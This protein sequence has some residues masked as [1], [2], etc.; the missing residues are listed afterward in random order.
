MIAE[1]KSLLIANRGEIACR[2]IATAKKMGITTYVIYNEANKFSRYVSLSDYAIFIEQNSTDN[3][4][5][6]S[7][8][9]V[10]LAK[11]H[12][13]DAIHPG[14]GF[15]SENASFAAKVREA[16]LQFIG[17]TASCIKLMGNK[18]NAR[19]YLAQHGIPCIPGIMNVS[20]SKLSLE[21]AAELGYPIMIKASAGGG[22]RGMRRVDAE[23]ELIDAIESAM[24][25]AEKAFGDGIVYGEK[26]IAKAR[27]VEVQIAGDHFGKIIHLGS[28]ECSLQR[29]HQK[30]VEWAEANLAEKTHQSMIACAIKIGE[31]I[32]YQNLGTIEFLVDEDE[33]F[34]FLEMNT[35]LQV[36]HPVTE[37]ITDLDLVE[38][39]IQI[40]NNQAIKA[41]LIKPHRHAMEVRLCA[42]DPS[43]QF[44]PQTGHVFFHNLDQIKEARI[45]HGLNLSE[46]ITAKY[47]S[48]LAKIIVAGQS[49]ENNLKQLISVLQEIKIIGVVTNQYYLIQLLQDLLSQQKKITTEYLTH[50][51]YAKEKINH[52]IIIARLLIANK[53]NNQTNHG[54]LQS[55][56]NSLFLQSFYRLEYE[57]DFY[58]CYIQSNHK[59]EYQLKINN[60]LYTITNITISSQEIVC[61]IN[62]MPVKFQY[63]HSNESIIIFSEHA[64]YFIR[65]ITYEHISANKIQHENHIIAPMDG[66]IVNVEISE[67]DNIIKGQTLLTLESMKM[68]HHLK[69]SMNGQVA[70]LLIK[71]GQQVKGQQLLVELN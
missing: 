71:T 10:N 18:I 28:R 68:E 3:F 42:E 46:P 41:P 17:P 4:F 22:G 40:E 55:F 43:Q 60:S 23:A 16:G 66:A 62:N 8:L 24:R 33:H 5:L 50:F 45:D 2:I 35:R 1:I 19:N 25:E 64:Q 39:Q 6:D 14:Y 56:T 53:E 47:D 59:N 63:Y 26:L 65:E 30:I 27:H 70:K 57:N 31:L 29:R 54:C 61:S 11:Q 44:L 67:G 48:L 49:F 38:M 34:Y 69:A 52:N 32:K 15:L 36:E 7:H 37:M 58:D 20:P 9:I 13:I 51:Q 12:G 21:K